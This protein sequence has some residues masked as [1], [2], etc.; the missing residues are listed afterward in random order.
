MQEY[1]CTYLCMCVR[2]YVCVSIATR[3][4]LEAP[5]YFGNLP[6]IRVIVKRSLNFI[7][8][9][10]ETVFPLLIPTAEALLDGSS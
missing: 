9:R 1:L 7:S 3:Y 6:E 5:S 10:T 2:V 4:M 8:L